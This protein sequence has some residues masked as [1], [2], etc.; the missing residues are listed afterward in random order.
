MVFLG[1]LKLAHR[2]AIFLL[3]NGNFRALWRDENN[4]QQVGLQFLGN[5]TVQYVIFVREGQTDKLKT[6]A[7]T[8]SM[9]AM[10]PLI[11]SASCSYLL[12]G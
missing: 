10:L 1:G 7:S 4:K 12:F 11:A 8:G 2:P 9:R 3:D 6:I 5:E